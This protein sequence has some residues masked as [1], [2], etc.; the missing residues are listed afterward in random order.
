MSYKNGNGL[1]LTHRTPALFCTA[2]IP[3]WRTWDKWCLTS[4]AKHDTLPDVVSARLRFS[5]I[6]KYLPAGYY[7]RLLSRPIL[8]LN[9]VKKSTTLTSD[10]IYI[11]TPVI[12][13][14]HFSS[15]FGR[16]LWINCSFS[17]I[18]GRSFLFFLL[19]LVV[20][21][22]FLPSCEVI[23]VYQYF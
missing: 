5:G 11:N 15:I 8:A 7:K 9:A 2:G 13:R 22:R 1:P 17:C 3:I 23:F 20:V 10:L 12:F 18:R 4:C 19:K 6:P 21:R 16:S 14:R